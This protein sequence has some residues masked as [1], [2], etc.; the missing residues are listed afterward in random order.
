MRTFG[1][2]PEFIFSYKPG[3]VYV[4]L[5]ESATLIR[6]T[7]SDGQSVTVTIATA[8]PFDTRV[9][10]LVSLSNPHAS[11]PFILSL[12]IPAWAQPPSSSPSSV[13]ILV[14]GA[15]RTS[16]S[17]G[18]YAVVDL[19]L[20]GDGTVVNAS[21]VLSA[22]PAAILYTGVTQISPWQRFGYTFG[23]F[24]LASVGGWDSAL[25]CAVIN[26]SAVPGFDPLAPQSWLLAPTGTP[27]GALPT[28]GTDFSVRGV[29]GTVMRP[30]YRV[31]GETFTAFPIVVP[32][33]AAQKK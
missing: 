30:Y 28:P 21:F 3:Q 12:R 14:D 10:V 31:D 20:P 23:P 18:S 9:D 27:P 7:A 16:G 32:A 4:N 26:G 19:M 22:A 11:S 17:P 1:A 33:V 6:A 13:P 2:V 8:W 24:L 15:P 5:F 25:N 29:N